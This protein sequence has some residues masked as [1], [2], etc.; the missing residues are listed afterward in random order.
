VYADPD[1][2]QYVTEGGERVDGTW[3]PPEDGSDT[4]VVEWREG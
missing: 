1:G 2:R 4:P 3:L